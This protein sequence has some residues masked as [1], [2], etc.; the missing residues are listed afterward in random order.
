M[1]P[2]AHHSLLALKNRANRHKR[3]KEIRER[4]EF[5]QEKRKRA[6]Q[7]RREDDEDDEDDDDDGERELVL[8]MMEQSLAKAVTDIPLYRYPPTS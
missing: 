7:N 5:L 2:L 8:L 3:E 1:F 6:M 4:L